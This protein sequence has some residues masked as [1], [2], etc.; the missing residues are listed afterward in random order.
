MQSICKFV[1]AYL[2]VGRLEFAPNAYKGY[3]SIVPLCY[4]DG[5]SP[6]LIPMQPSLNNGI[7]H[8][9]WVKFI[10]SL[11]CSEEF[12]SSF[13]LSQ[14]HTHKTEFHLTDFATAYLTLNQTAKL[15]DLAYLQR[16]FWYTPR[17]EGAFNHFANPHVFPTFKRPGMR[18]A[19]HC[20]AA[21]VK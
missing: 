10:G 20:F 8:Q 4:H 7:Q 11:P 3:L 14:T 15:Q 1:V 19:S 5:E 12:F 16:S 21:I 2:S 13:P 9:M 6:H 18:T 17:Q